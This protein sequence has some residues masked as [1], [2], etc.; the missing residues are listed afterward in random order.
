MC[1][2]LVCPDPAFALNMCAR[3]SAMYLSAGIGQGV[4]SQETRRGAAGR[5]ILFFS[6]FLYTHRKRS[7]PFHSVQQ[8]V[9][10]TMAISVALSYGI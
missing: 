3:A 9:V 2:A 7:V 4:G 10:K 8:Y 5:G 1:V 6:Y